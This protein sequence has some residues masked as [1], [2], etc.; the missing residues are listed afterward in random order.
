M[1]KFHWPTGFFYYTGQLINSHCLFCH[2]LQVF[3]TEILRTQQCHSSIHIFIHSCIPGCVERVPLPQARGQHVGTKENR[4]ISKDL[5]AAWLES[6]PES[7]N[8]GKLG[9][10]QA[11]KRACSTCAQATCGPDTPAQ[12]LENGSRSPV[13]EQTVL[14]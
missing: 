7:R 10:D 11:E 12:S 6:K 1:E 13:G 8:W 9:Q 4:V 14:S 5:K 2:V 3:Y